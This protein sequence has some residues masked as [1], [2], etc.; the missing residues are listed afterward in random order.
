MFVGDD[1]MCDEE[2]GRQLVQRSLSFGD[3]ESIPSES[4][5]F[6]SLSAARA[7][8]E[9]MIGEKVNELEAAARKSLAER[10]GR[11]RGRLAVYYDYRVQAGKERLEATLATVERLRQSADEGERRILPVWEARL[12]DDEERIGAL[13]G[14][15]HRRLEELDRKEGL[16]ADYE[17]VQVVRVEVTP[18]VSSTIGAVAG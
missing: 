9:A 7:A 2:R 10:L 18:A 12:H 17:L 15:R 1:G 14:E 4:L 16:A 11:E 13:E 3:E 5:P 8:A 6:D